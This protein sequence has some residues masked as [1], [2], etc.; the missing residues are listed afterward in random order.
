MPAPLDL[1]GRRFGHLVALARER[2][3]RPARWLCRCD[4]GAGTIA[5][6]RRL[7]S[8]ADGDRRAVRAC[9]ACRSRRC[10]VCGAPYLAAGSAAT[11]GA[12]A[13]RLRNRRAVN[14][15]AEKRAERRDPGRKARRMRAHVSAMKSDPARRL[16]ALERD[17]MRAR[18][19]RARLT[20]AQ[21]QQGR[22]AA[23]AY[24]ERNRERVR[25]RFAAWLAGLSPERW[26]RWDGRARGAGRAYRRRR[27]VARM[28]A[29][30]STLLERIN[31]R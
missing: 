12:D 22:A 27:A 11:C 4:C 14:Q 8:A 25:V 18:L 31:S 26:A 9:E 13:C 15:R 21:R 10:A 20:P 6:L 23:R 1:T 2:G 7:S 19:R 29:D 24:Y 3:S 16:V 17:R 30:A 28:M 5:P